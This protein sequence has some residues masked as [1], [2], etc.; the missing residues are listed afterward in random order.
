ATISD[1]LP[2]GASLS[3][4]VTCAG[5]GTANCT[6]SIGAADD[7][8]FTDNAVD[9]AADVDGVDNVNGPSDSY[10]TYTVPVK[11]STNM[12]DYTP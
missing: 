10:V 6:A 2:N 11:F 12:N 9:I 8:S 1:V 5:T 4:P 3:G 7:V